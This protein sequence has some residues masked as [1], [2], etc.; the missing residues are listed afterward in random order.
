MN[1]L[2]EHI[3]RIALGLA[4]AAGCLVPSNGQVSQRETTDLWKTVLYAEDVDY[5]AFAC[6]ASDVDVVNSYFEARPLNKKLPICH[7]DCP[8]IS[9]RP[10]IYFPEAAKAV[11]AT[12]SVKVH[13][14][15]DEKGKVLYARALSGHPLLRASAIQ[16]ACRT[17]FKEYSDHKHQGVME[18]TVDNFDYLTVPFRANTVW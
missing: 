11:K 12:G 18:F 2:K 4:C 3:V 15:V 8:I 1:A 9:C 10:V 6:D 13:V 14:L 5:G 7:N 17:Q 16:G